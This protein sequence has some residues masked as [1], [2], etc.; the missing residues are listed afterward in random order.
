MASPAATHRIRGPSPPPARCRAASSPTAGAGSRRG[1]R[2]RLGG[3]CADR[4]RRR[5]RPSGAARDGSR[6]RSRHL[7][8]ARRPGRTRRRTAGSSVR[9]RHV[10][11]RPTRSAGDRARSPRQR[12]QCLVPTG[13]G[14]RSNAARRPRPATWRARRRRRRASATAPARVTSRC[15]S[16]GSRPTAG[17]A[18][19][20]P[21]TPGWRQAPRRPCGSARHRRRGRD[22]PHVRHRRVDGAPVRHRA[23]HWPGGGRPRRSRAAIPEPPRA[24][25]R[26]TGG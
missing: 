17:R 6:R 12:W 11:S 16:T 4:Q 2:G 1:R 22:R 26:N 9:S 14:D 8:P 19:A 10:A 25:A 24:S 3:R 5:P 15:R 13:T 23:V 18:S 7:R 20:R 21:T